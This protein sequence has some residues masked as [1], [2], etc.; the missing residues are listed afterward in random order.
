M[1]RSEKGSLRLEVVLHILVE[2]EVILAE[3]RENRDIERHARDPVQDHGVA[4]NL[5]RGGRHTLLHHVAQE[6]V[7][8]GRFGGRTLR[9]NLFF[10]PARPGKESAIGT[11]DPRA[12][13]ECLKSTRAHRCHGGFTVGARHAHERDFARRFSVDKVRCETRERARILAH[14]SGVL[15]HRMRGS[16]DRCTR[17]VREN[18]GASLLK[19][20]GSVARAVG[21]FPLNRDKKRLFTRFAG[22]DCDCRNRHA[23]ASHLEA[24]RSRG[25]LESPGK[26]SQHEFG[27]ITHDFHFHSFSSWVP[28]VPEGAIPRR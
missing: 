12:L 6:R 7:H 15:R 1:L 14:E 16:Q 19:G 2:I 17:L 8:V 9:R 27:A 13:A 21:I 4:R 11:D 24:S 5:E 3:I 22:V 25:P 23:F 20:C 26:V 28:G 18:R 10:A